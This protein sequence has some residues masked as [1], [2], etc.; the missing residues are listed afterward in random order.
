MY[1]KLT[2]LFNHFI[3]FPCFFIWKNRIFFWVGSIRK[4][5]RC[6][7]NSEVTGGHDRV[8][9]NTFQIRITNVSWC[10]GL[11]DVLKVYFS[12]FLQKVLNSGTC[13]VE[14]RLHSVRMTTVCVFLR[15]AVMMMG[16]SSRCL[17]F[18]W[19]WSFVLSTNISSKHKNYI[20]RCEQKVYITLRS[21]VMMMGSSSRCC[22]AY[23][24]FD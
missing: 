2:L 17:Q 1:S 7:Q 14:S 24:F 18:L 3:E 5:T 23:S 4:L 12:K 19:F 22:A 13:A 20:K 10:W 16:S 8:S 21:A 15:S 11:Q 9:S 6:F